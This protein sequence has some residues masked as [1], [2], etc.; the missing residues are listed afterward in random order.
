MCLDFSPFPH[1]FFFFSLTKHIETDFLAHL[2]CLVPGDAGVISFI[3][4]DD[5]FYHQL[6]AVLIQTVLIA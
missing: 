1:S 3:H 5:I 2:A 4:F 6:G